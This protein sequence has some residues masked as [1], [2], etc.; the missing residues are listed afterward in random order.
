MLMITLILQM[1]HRKGKHLAQGCI[2][3]KWQSWDSDSR[4]RMLQCFLCYFVSPF[5]LT[6]VVFSL[7]VVE[8]GKLRSDLL[9]LH[10]TQ[11]S[12]LL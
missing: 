4:N 8:W 1:R 11:V 7:L 3:S 2:A 6:L 10:H 9:S 12:F 5:R